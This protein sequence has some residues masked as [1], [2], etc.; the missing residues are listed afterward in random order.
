VIVIAADVVG[1]AANGY[2]VALINPAITETADEEVIGQEGC[3]SFPKVFANV[4]RPVHVVVEAFTPSGSAFTLTAHG[5]FARAIC[6]ELE[7]LD[8]KLLIDHT[9]GLKRQM[10][11]NKMIK[12]RRRLDKAAKRGRPK[13]RK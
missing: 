4:P 5:F 6:H 2:P 12:F 11:A 9:S 3:L 1:E 7:H 8:G 10:I 13:R